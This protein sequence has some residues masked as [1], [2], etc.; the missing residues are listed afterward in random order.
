MKSMTQT[1]NLAPGS[2]NGYDPAYPAPP[3][4]H[5]IALVVVWWACT[6]LIG[7]YAPLG[8]QQLL[9][10]LITDAWAFYLCCWI[11]SI[12]AEAKSPF[13]C[14][15]YVIVE[16]TFATLGAWRNPP[17]IMDAFIAILGFASAILAIATI[18]LIKRDLE[19]HYNEREP[20]GL[21]LNGLMT[22]F[23]SFLYFQSHLYRIAKEKQAQSL[24]DLGPSLP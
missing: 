22:F 20:V 1:L 6:W 9:V 16:L 13:W 12:N 14:D 8:Y 7:T 24:A 19:K 17:K 23:F 10:S 4:V 3:R 2:P 11:R 15:V 21:V 18:F 5:W